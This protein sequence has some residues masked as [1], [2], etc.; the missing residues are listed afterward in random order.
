MCVLGKE[1]KN[2]KEVKEKILQDLPLRV[3]DYK[4][5]SVYLFFF[6]CVYIFLNFQ[7]WDHIRTVLLLFFFPKLKYFS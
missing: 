1:N 3:N 6:L 2:C 4:H 5:I 7:N